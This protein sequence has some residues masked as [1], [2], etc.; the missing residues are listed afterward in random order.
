[1]SYSIWLCVAKG[2]YFSVY[3]KFSIFEIKYVKK[4]AK[5]F[6]S[7][8]VLP[9]IILD[10]WLLASSSSEVPASS[11]LRSPSPSTFNRR[12]WKTSSGVVAKINNHHHDHMC[13][14]QGQVFHYK[15]RNQGY[16]SAQG[17][18][19][20]AYSGTTVGVLLGINRCGSFPLLSESLSL[21]SISNTP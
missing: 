5:C 7:H 16:S 13:F 21:F 1:M 20:N 9:S 8:C 10:S 19:S 11:I 6:F 2:P 18:S 4:R 12:L 15:S 3:H 14:V 17:R